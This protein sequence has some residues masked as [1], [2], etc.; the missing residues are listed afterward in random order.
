MDPALAILLPVVVVI[1]ACSAKALALSC[2]DLSDEGRRRL[3]LAVGTLILVSLGY[4][5][6]L[7]VVVGLDPRGCPFNGCS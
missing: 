4:L 3:N 2:V 7:G 6:V 5:V 1:G